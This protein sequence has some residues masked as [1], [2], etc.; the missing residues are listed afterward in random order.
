M[1]IEKMKKKIIIGLIGLLLLVNANALCCENCTVNGTHY[2]FYDD[3]EELEQS[4]ELWSTMDLCGCAM[5][6]KTFEER[7]RVLRWWNDLSFFMKWFERLKWFIQSED[8]Y[9][10]IIYL[11]QCGY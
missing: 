3:F 7:R 11:T 1:E 10:S 4:R 2:I 9:E 5:T 8:L 6:L